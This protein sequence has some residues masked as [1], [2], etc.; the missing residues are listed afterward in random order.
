MV[1]ALDEMNSQPI[2]H[3][4][5]DLWHAASAWRARLHREMVARGYA[6]YGDARAAIAQSLDVRGLTQSELV[7]RMGISKQ[8]VQ[9]LLDGLEAEG[10]IRRSLDPHDRRG[11]R[12]EY[13]SA[14]LRAVR[15]ANAIKRRM[16]LELRER[17][18][19]Q[20]FEKMRAALREVS[21]TLEKNSVASATSR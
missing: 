13:T 11:K 1:K 15:D 2:D 7:A 8:A 20:A 4:G 17:L 5:L 18:G 16:E 10:V 6:W 14:G 12:V 9:Q 3:V 19:P 21:R